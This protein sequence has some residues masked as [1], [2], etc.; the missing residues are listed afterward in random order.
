MLCA[1]GYVGTGLVVRPNDVGPQE[2]I[3][4]LQLICRRVGVR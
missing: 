3:T 2:V 4:G 1:S